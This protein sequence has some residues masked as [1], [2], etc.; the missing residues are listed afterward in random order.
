MKLDDPTLSDH[1][2]LVDPVRAGLSELR[3]TELASFPVE[4]SDGSLERLMIAT[5]LGV[6]EGTLGG[7]TVDGMPRLTLELSLWRNIPMSA[8]VNV[9]AQHGAH[10]ARVL[11]NIG[12]RTVSSWS[13]DTRQAAIDFIAE[14]LRQASQSGGR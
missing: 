11:L 2:W 13:L 6:V 10:T 7:P 1:N 12:E 9:D 3:A 8:R 4:A 14:A 5:D